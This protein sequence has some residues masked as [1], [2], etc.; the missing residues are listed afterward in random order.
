MNKLLKNQPNKVQF[1]P[2]HFGGYN[3]FMMLSGFFAAVTFVK[4]WLFVI[5]AIVCFLIAARFYMLS[6]KYYAEIEADE[7]YIDIEGG[8]VYN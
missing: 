7:D 4:H 8:N 3:M 5:G 1:K 2:E 6:Q